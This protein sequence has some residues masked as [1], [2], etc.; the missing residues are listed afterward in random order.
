MLIPIKTRSRCLSHVISAFDGNTTGN[1]HGKVLVTCSSHWTEAGTR[2]TQ[3]VTVGQA[4]YFDHGWDRRVV[5][6]LVCN[7]M[8]EWL[9]DR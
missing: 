4:W 5:H 6:T 2:S 7:T 3:H 1:V 8:S 9:G